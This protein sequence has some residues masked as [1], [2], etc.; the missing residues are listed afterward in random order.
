MM[1]IRSA[2]TCLS[3]ALSGIGIAFTGCA[4]T[5]TADPSSQAGVA[6]QGM[7][8]GGQQPIV[9]A[10]V[11]LLAA[12]TTGYGGNGIAASTSNASLSLLKSVAGSTALDSSGGATNGFYY[13]TTAGDGSFSITNDYTCTAGQQ[14]YLYTLGGT[15][16]GVANTAAAGLAILGNCPGGSLA[17]QD[18]YVYV[19]EVS[20]VAA[21]YAFA[22]FATDAT[23][24]S[25]SGTTLAKVGIANAFANA[26][27]L[28]TLATGTALATTPAGGGVA[29]Q[30]TVGTLAN[31]L[32]SCINSNGAVT[33]PTNPTTCYT[34]FYNSQSSAGVIPTDTANSAINIAH[35]PGSNITALYG[36]QVAAAPFGYK[37]SAQPNDFTLGLSFP[38]GGTGIA[39]DASG[40]AWIANYNSVTELS[41]SGA[42]LSPTGGFAGNGLFIPS[43]FSTSNSSSAIAIDRS[44]N[45]WVASK[46]SG[47][48]ELSNSGAGISPAGGYDRTG[49]SGVVS[50]ALDASG[51]V[52]VGNYG[53]NTVVKLSSTGGVLSGTTGYTGGGIQAPSGIAI[54]G[55]A[56]AWT[57]NYNGGNVSEFSNSGVPIS[58]AAG[59]TGGGLESTT[60]IAMDS[61]GNAWIADDDA[62]TK[63]SHSGVAISPS[64]GYTGGG[65]LY[66]QAIAIDGAGDAWVTNAYT[67]VSELSNAGTGISAAGKYPAG[68]YQG[69]GLQYASGIAIDGSGDVWALN[70][71]TSSSTFTVVE[72]I[73]AA[74]PV[75][76][77][78]A[79]G[80]PATPTADG[81]SNLGTRP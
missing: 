46:N 35:N 52:W 65:L 64:A 47:I 34:L 49:L 30:T 17:T 21:A 66:P 9:G 39:I 3:L 8:H 43:G 56:N 16:S 79:A 73:G 61:A 55:S 10:H 11:Y 48:S 42:V 62:V 75:D 54:D 31:I 45:V 74:V 22:G 19:N 44:G 6:I 27:N 70:F 57:A 80:L 68:G 18:P 5:S 37:L 23:H 28:A 53:A 32:A 25:S 59:F 13:V 14:V 58:P 26:G 7:L 78:I 60:L 50:L 2:R 20:T 24:V 38:G 71:N 67:G 29:P 63:F 81:S 15:V 40:N 4:L 12:N 72:L 36:L 33:G 51:S 77:P 1:N 76:T 41:S 69:G